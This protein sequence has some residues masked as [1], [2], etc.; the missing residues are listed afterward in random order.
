M[1]CAPEEQLHNVHGWIMHM[2]FFSPAGETN[3]PGKGNAVL[4]SQE[5]ILAVDRLAM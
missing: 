1:G 5:M 4:D 2:P 3:N